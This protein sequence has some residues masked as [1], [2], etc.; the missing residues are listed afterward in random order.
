MSLHTDRL[1]NARERKGL[2][3]REL[4]QLCGLGEQQIYRYETDRSEPT[5]THLKIV[6]DT[7]EVS[8]DYLL[9][10]TDDPGGHIG[11]TDLNDE[12]RTILSAFRQKGWSGLIHLIA[13]RVAERI[14]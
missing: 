1:R 10:R 13:D 14:R 4:A 6:A 3:Q 11:S 8:T 7:L 2:T 5:A 9:G 12:E